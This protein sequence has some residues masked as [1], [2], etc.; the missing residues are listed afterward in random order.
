MLSDFRFALRSLA[1]N[2]GFTVVAVLTLALGIGVNTSMFSVLNALLL[3]T[4][5]Y[6]EPDRLLRVYRTTPTLRFS[7]HSTANFLDLQAQAK[8]FT[9]LA[10]FSRSSSNLADPGQPAAQVPTLSVSGDF[11]A[12]F[13]VQPLLGRAIVPA[14]DRAGEAQVIVLSEPFWRQRFAADPA[15][16]GRQIRLDGEPV[17]VIGVMP[18]GFEDRLVWGSLSGWRPFR[19]SDELRQDRGGNWLSLVGRLQPRVTAAQ[20]RSELDTLFAALARTYPKDN[21]RSGVNVSP[22]VRSMQDTTTRLMPLFAMGLAGCVLLI[23]CANLANLLFAR[24]VLRAREHAIRAALGATRFQLIRQSLTESLLLA[25]GGGALGVLLAAWGNAAVG[26]QLVIAGQPFAP[27]LDWRVAGFAFGVAALAAVVFGLLP[28]LLASRTDVNDALKQGARGSTNAAHHRMRHALIVLEVALALVLLSGAGFF[29]RGLDRFFT[30]D[31][32]WQPARLL[33]AN[34]SLPSA[35][36]ADDAAITAFLD[37]LDAQLRALPGVEQASLSHTLPFYGFGWGQRYIVEGRAL[38]TPG[39]EPLRDVNLVSPAYFETLGITLLEGRTFT[40][41]DRTGPLRMVIGESMARQ[42]WPGE[43]AL[44][45][46]IA[47]PGRPTE[48]QEIIGVVRDIKFAS[49]LEDTPTRVQTYRLLSRE[50]DSEIS[51]ALRSAVPPAVLAAELRRTLARLDPE[52]SLSQVLPALAVA[53]QDTANYTLIGWILLGFAL[54]GLGLAAIGLYGVISGFVAQRTPEIG[55]R[56]AL[57]AELRD[58]LRLVLGQGLRLALFGTVLGLA[59]A[60]GVAALLRSLVPG[61]PAAEP[62]TALAV[63]LTLLAT[64]LVACWLP[65]R[66]ATRVDPMIALR[67]E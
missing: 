13:G 64:T 54:L 26:A 9:H 6:P 62:A 45:K 51:L 55:L 16:V 56:M 30:R 44:G 32:G 52:I 57:G 4:P 61:L 11:F 66:R 38:P 67:A 7:P 22:F 27:D 58:I 37:R 24:N 42:L 34:L 47:H 49:N 17:T 59:G 65:A 2:R 12:L 39:T 10:A 14:D 41:A 3:H 8:S 33:T 60:W 21:A 1:K 50:P 23:A 35:S 29:L 25:L 15:I 53:E 5:M 36:Y 63:T 40:D 20:A 28:A 48:W 43:S 46:R 19:F 18:A 31:H